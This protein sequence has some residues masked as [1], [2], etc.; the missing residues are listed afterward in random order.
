MDNEEEY[1]SD[2]SQNTE[3]LNEVEEGDVYETVIKKGLDRKTTKQIKVKKSKPIPIPKK[4][5]KKKVNKE[6]EEEVLEEVVNEIIEQSP[7]EKTISEK[8]LEHLA[9]ARE[10]KANK[11]TI[12]KTAVKQ[13]K[14]QVKK[15]MPLRTVEKTKVIYMIPTNNGF[16][17][18]DSIPKLTKRELNFLD[19]DEIVTKEEQ[20]IGKKI[21]RKK[22]GSADGRSKRVQTEKQKEATKKMLETNRKRRE[23]KKQETEETLGAQVKKAMI[24]IVTKPINELK[25]VEPEKPKTTQYDFS[26]ITPFF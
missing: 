18:S 25:K 1:M 24:D 5:N 16:I 11:L 4:N 19:N 3:Q 10:A 2:D 22:N 14:R 6:I 7:S 21:I 12:K 15:E 17:E 9:K 20:A 8:R 13:I 23:S 26:N